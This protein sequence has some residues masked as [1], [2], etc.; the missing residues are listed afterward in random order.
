MNQV[1]SNG[2]R[3]AY[4][5]EAA[6]APGRPWLVFSHS[7]AADHRMW[8]PQVA[9]FTGRFNIL[10]YDMRGHGA[11]EAPPPPY[12]LEQLA[13]D[14]RAVLDA[15]GVEHCHYVGLSLGGMVG[16][17]AALR[18]PRR[19]HSLVLADTTSRYP[20][21]MRPVWEERIAAVRGPNGMAAVAP[22]TLERWFT[23]AF[24]DREPDTVAR[25]GLQIRATPVNGYVGCAQ[26]IMGLNL[27]ARLQAIA[28]PVLVIVGEEDPGTPPAMAEEIVRAIDGA[29]LVRIPQAAHLSNLEQPARFNEALAAFFA[30]LEPAG[31]T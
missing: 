19:F 12:T 24:R 27:T 30:A 29:R 16:Q 13:D 25:I 1:Q 4:R 10:R 17:I 7:L 31:G 3:I 28:V 6:T 14:L 20:A 18:Y 26:A 11:S 15:A 8:D 5:I 9:A 22:G 23:A 21:E 2:C